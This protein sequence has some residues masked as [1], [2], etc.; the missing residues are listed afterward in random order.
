MN[1]AALEMAQQLVSEHAKKVAMRFDVPTDAFT[2]VL[3]PKLKQGDMFIAQGPQVR[4]MLKWP[5]VLPN[6]NT[7]L[8]HA[9]ERIRRHDMYTPLE[10]G[11]RG[12]AHNV[13]NEKSGKVRRWVAKNTRGNQ[14][15]LVHDLIS[16]E[17]IRI[18]QRLTTIY[19]D[20]LTGEEIELTSE[21]KFTH[22]GQHV[23]QS[24]VTLS[25][26]VFERH[27]EEL[28]DDDDDRYGEASDNQRVQRDNSTSDCVALVLHRE[29]PLP[30]DARFARS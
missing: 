10:L 28:L 12:W 14:A 15:M 4:I 29:S 5:D 21:M 25:Q 30:A 24:W 9:F 27:P 7:F 22:T 18:T 17:R 11:T 16:P 23:D 2:I 26:L 8:R 13:K 20:V 1:K 3:V 19:K 6:M